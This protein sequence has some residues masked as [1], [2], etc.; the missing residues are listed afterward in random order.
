[1]KA[2]IRITALTLLMMPVLVSAQ[3]PQHPLA[4]YW[5]GPMV[6][7]GAEDTDVTVE[8]RIQGEQ[9]TGPIFANG[10]ERYIKQGT[11]TA[12]SVSFTSPGLKAD[13]VDVPMVWTAQLTGNNELAVSVVREDQQGPAHEFVLTKRQ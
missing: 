12:N 6:A 9:V 11:V 5:R 10:L 4:G 2:L 7:G 8:F 1:M 13:D 3:E